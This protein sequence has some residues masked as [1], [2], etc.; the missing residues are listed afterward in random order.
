MVV[1]EL[2]AVV[3]L[4][5]VLDDAL[6]RRSSDVHL[7]ANENQLVVQFRVAGALQPY[8]RL[9]EFGAAV[10]RRIKALARM[11]V[12]ESRLPQDGAFHWQGGTLACDVRA[13]SLPTVHGEVMVLRL[14]PRQTEAMTFAGL[15]MTPEQ[16]ATMERLLRADSGLCLVTGRTGSGKTTT[17]YTMMAQ[18]ALWGR[19]VVSIEDPVEMTLAACHQVEVR[20]RVGITFDRGLRALLRHD[21]D[22]IM[23]GE[24]RDDATAQVALR[25]A[26]T[27]HLVLSTTH[28]PDLPG[29]A[30]RLV[31]FGLSRPLLGDV[32]KAVVVQHLAVRTCP[33]C[34][35]AGC[36]SCGSAGA[37]GLRVAAFSIHEMTS[38]LGALFAS[39]RSWHEVRAH[40]DQDIERGRVQ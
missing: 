33:D 22:V 9:E 25:A 6:A 38:D 14:L 12:A 2:S 35:G 17:L 11:D 23:I 30:A 24:I 8:L 19:H 29:A 37:P 16:C 36:A 13:A 1:E 26:L 20:E 10:I 3:L 31:E 21:P 40:L 27:G 18:L 4:Q 15:G 34:A 7:E 39:G 28:A 32:L 5:R